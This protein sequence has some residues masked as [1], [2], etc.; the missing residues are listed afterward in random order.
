MYVFFKDSLNYGCAF[1]PFYFLPISLQI[2]C[3]NCITGEYNS[4]TS[5]KKDWEKQLTLIPLPFYVSEEKF[6]AFHKC[7]CK[8]EF[9]SDA[10]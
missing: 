5:F 1:V 6:L 8:P 4:L 3:F 2:N 10:K 9:R 7:R